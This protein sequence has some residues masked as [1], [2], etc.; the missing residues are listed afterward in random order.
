MKVYGTLDIHSNQRRNDMT[1]RFDRRE[2]LKKSA[3][4]AG[5]VAGVQAFG[6][7]AIMAERS[8]NSKLGTAVI[9]SNGRGMAHMG[10]AM[11]EHLVALVDVDDRRMAA[12]LATL[13]KR[14]G[15]NASKVK[16]FFDYRRTTAPGFWP[17]SA[18]TRST[19]STGACNSAIPAVAWPWNRRGRPPACGRP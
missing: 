9:G 1:A 18:P 3:I 14:P 10:P 6:V 15:F 13:G 19:P 5:A 12:T 16:T 17:A 2:L 11:S 8:P 4:A 7:P